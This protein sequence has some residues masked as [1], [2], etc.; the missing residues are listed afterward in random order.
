[1]CLVIYQYYCALG[2][3]PKW[4][5][6]WDWCF[7][8]WHFT[9]FHIK[10]RFR[11]IFLITRDPRF[12]DDRIWQYL[13]R[14]LSSS[15]LFDLAGIAWWRHQM[16]KF[17]AL[18][19]ICAGN[20]PVPGEFPAQRP[21]TRSFDVF[22]DLRLNQRLSKNSWGW[23]FETLPRPLWRH[24]NGL[25]C[26]KLLNLALALAVV[27]NCIF[28]RKG[29]EAITYPCYKFDGGL[30]NFLNHALMSVTLL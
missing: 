29:W 3:I 9:R 13:I 21:V 14:R 17:S 6:K 30:A 11:W 2:K 26:G 10:M 25:Q 24:C 12:V 20:S 23:W 8:T 22:F 18:L 19:A 15:G 1:M 4:F 16:D 27:S 7:G 5:D 28:F